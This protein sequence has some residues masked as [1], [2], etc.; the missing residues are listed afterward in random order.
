MVVLAMMISSYLFL[1]PLFL[2]IIDWK[3]MLSIMLML[4]M[5][6]PV[7]IIPWQI[8][9]EL[10]AVVISDAP[11]PYYLWT[12]AKRRLFYIFASLG[13]FMMMLVLS[14]YFGFNF[15]DIMQTYIVFLVPLVLTTIVYSLIY[16]NNFSEPMKVSI[17]ERFTEW[18]EKRCRESNG[19]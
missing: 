14:V 12:G 18:K 15:I 5:F 13:A 4:S 1:N 6:V 11:R 17:V 2:S 3:T 19:E 7:L 9:K 16:A 10:G 8:V